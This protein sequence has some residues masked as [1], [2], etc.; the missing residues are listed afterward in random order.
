[1]SHHTA[2]IHR[3]VDRQTNEIVATLCDLIRIN[4]VNPYSGGG[5]TG[6][7]KPGQEYM[8]PLFQH[9]GLKTRLE[10]VHPDVYRKADILGPSPRDFSGRPNLLAEMT[11][12]RSGPHVF[13][14][15][16]MDTVA[17]DGMTVA[18]FDPVRRDGRIYGRG[19][20]DDKSGLVVALYAVRTLLE[21]GLELGGKL[22]V[23]SVVDEECD[24]GGSGVM[25]ILL[26]GHR[27][28]LSVCLDG[29]SDFIARGC[30]GVIT[31][32]V[33]ISGVSAHASSPRGVSALDNSWIVKQALEAVREERRINCPEGLL[34]IGVLRAGSHPAM[35]PGTAEILF[36][37]SYLPREAD[38]A[39]RAGRGYNGSLLRQR[40]E[41]V[42]AAAAAA[43]EY[44]RGHPPEVT[45]VKDLPP[46]LTAED[47]SLVRGM[48]RACA[49][50]DGVA[51]HVRVAPYWTDASNVP[52]LTGQDV[53]AFGAGADC[54]HAPDE[55]VEE[56]VL[57][58]NTKVLAQFLADTLSHQPP[59]P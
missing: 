22:T 34:N 35:V 3:H 26:N 54:A 12:P 56:T 49:A 31:G 21:L 23:A 14:F 58:R 32:R 40:I 38:D 24:G 20:S 10:T 16:H 5:V 59:L 25:S 29:S 8:E 42:V 44:L 39:R 27:P 46:F 30:N 6:S 53:I 9:L 19:S 13:L 51:P 15:A 36:N 33:R 45:W 28:D 18:P 41:D 17:V 50:I 43:D 47:S 1:M 37:L 11:F 57:I 7:E 55:Y 4:T 2:F 52:L 48:C